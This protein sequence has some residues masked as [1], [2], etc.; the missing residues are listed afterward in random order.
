MT[1]TGN[2]L[3]R[4]LRRFHQTGADRQM[5]DSTD[6]ARGLAFGERWQGIPQATSPNA[7]LPADDNPLW[8]YFCAHTEGHGIW[9]W[10]Q[11]FDIY[12]RHLQ[13][14]RGTAVNLVEVG[15]YSGGSLQMWQSYFGDQVRI[16]GVDIEEAC[17][18]YESDRI[19]V[20]IGDQEDRAFWADFRSKVTD[21]NVFIDDG[22]HTPDQQMVTLEEMLP[23]MPAGSVFICEDI[24]GISNRFTSFACGLVTLLNAQNTVRGPIPHAAATPLQQ[25]LCSIHFYPYVVVIEKNQVAPSH[26]EAPK[27]GTEWQPFL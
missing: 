9:K 11:Y 6:F 21:V 18:C 24:H 10:T 16:H 12:H 27:H 26:L 2:P 17:R 3:K 19:S 5:L 8:K 22:G 25:S 20:H 13:R 14:Y 15:I 7:P 1:T 23:V 4:M